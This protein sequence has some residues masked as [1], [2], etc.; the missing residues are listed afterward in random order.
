MQRGDAVLIAPLVRRVAATGVADA[1]ATATAQPELHRL[2]VERVLCA[3]L[4]VGGHVLGVIYLDASEPGD[5]DGV[6]P[7]IEATTTLLG[8]ALDR[9]RLAGEARRRGDLD[10]D[11]RARDPQPAVRNPRL[12][13]DGHRGRSRRPEVARQLL[14]RIR[15][16]GERLRRLLEDVMALAKRE[17]RTPRRRRRP[18][19]TSRRSRATSRPASGRAASSARSKLSVDAT[20]PACTAVGDADRLA[21]VLANIVT[22]AIKF[23]PPGGSIRIAVGREAVTAGDPRLP[24]GSPTDPRAWVPMLDGE[25]AGEYVR[26]DVDDSGPG[27]DPDG[28]R[29]AVREVR[30]GPASAVAAASASACTSRARSSSATAAQSG[31]QRARRRRAVQLPPAG[32][33]AIVA[34]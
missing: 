28:R 26:V 19:S 34:P 7:I 6:D 18:R 1:I 14:T 22:N 27:L 16:D 21:Q 25:P 3:P 23:T 29:A 5:G 2:G 8:L 13:R 11:P 20:S 15:A 33:D 32:R 9:K 30:P 4:K 31:R 24:P 17:P 10:V 12:R